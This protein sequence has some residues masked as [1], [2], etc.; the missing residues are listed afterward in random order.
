[1][2]PRTQAIWG[3]I[4]KPTVEKSPTNAT[5]VTMPL[6]GQVIWGHI[7]IH[8]VEKSRRN[9]TNVIMPLIVQAIW[10]N[11]WKCTVEKSQTNAINVTR[12]LPMH[13]I[14]GHICK[15]TVEKSQTNA[16]NVTMPLL[17]Q[18]IWG[19]IWKHTVERKCYFIC[20]YPL[21]IVTNKHCC[22]W[23]LYIHC[24]LAD[25]LGSGFLQLR[26]KMSGQIGRSSE[27]YSALCTRFRRKMVYS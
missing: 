9:A 4:W 24:C 19:D 21:P 27:C 25:V 16:T 13:I 2:H 6:L 18:A 15:H 5:S 22:F 23:H 11:I 26:K 10:V 17:L 14:W 20:R 7:W 8:T 12:L 3:D 1:M